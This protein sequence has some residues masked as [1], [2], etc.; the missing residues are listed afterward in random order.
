MNGKRVFSACAWIGTLLLLALAAYLNDSA[1]ALTLAVSLGV[2]PLISLLVCAVGVKRLSCA[3]SLPATAEKNGGIPG[4]FTVSNA[5]PVFPGVVTAG[6]EA[7]NL[8]TDEAVSLSLRVSPLPKKASGTQFSLVSPHCGCFCLR[9]KNVRLLDWTGI[10]AFRIPA[11][12]DAVCAV[13]PGIFPVA[14]ENLPSST[15]EADAERYS[16]YRSGN[17]PTELFELREYV[18]GDDLRR[19]HRKLSEKLDRPVVRLDALPL[20]RSVLLLRDASV[21]SAAPPIRDAVTQSMVSVGQALRSEDVRFC[22]GWHASQGFFSVSVSS[23]ETLPDAVTALLGAPG[24]AADVLTPAELFAREHFGG[25]VLFS[26]GEPVSPPET[27]ARV[28]RFSS[29]GP[30]TPENHAEALSVLELTGE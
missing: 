12:P 14:L 17:D 8:L 18:P 30:L 5:F 25:V 19:L 21:L 20:Q 24:A 2:L 9:V 3:L 15:P 4:E 22:F 10:F 26:A 6:L 23:D 1:A 27:E 11:P 16:Q 13:L 7:V 29:N 28:L